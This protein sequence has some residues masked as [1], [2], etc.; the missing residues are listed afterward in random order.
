MTKCYAAT[1]QWL[2]SV[3]RGNAPASTLRAPCQHT[4]ASGLMLCPMR[5]VHAC[6][7]AVLLRLLSST[8][9]LLLYATSQTPKLPMHHHQQ[10]LFT[11]TT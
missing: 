4:C 10:Q 5:A 3:N 11:R 9:T 7:Q 2:L 8:H 6:M 1:P